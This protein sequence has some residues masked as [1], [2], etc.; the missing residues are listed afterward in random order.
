MADN[1][2][3][4]ED[5]WQRITSQQRAYENNSELRNVPAMAAYQNDSEPLPG[6][7]VSR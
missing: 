2:I 6:T 4:A 1:Y 5:K 7:R 3:T